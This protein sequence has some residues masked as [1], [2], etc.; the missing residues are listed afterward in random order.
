VEIL[1]AWSHISPISQV[2]GDKRESYFNI[3]YGTSMACP[4]VTGAASYVK[5]FH[6]NWSPAALKSALMTTG[7]AL[8]A[9]HACTTHF[10]AKY[11][12]LRQICLLIIC[13]YPY[14]SCTE[15]RC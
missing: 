3:I 9:I 13:S 4:H 2:E 1:A 12:C 15:C 11:I 8:L 5:Y 10:M 14:E 6:P 7:N